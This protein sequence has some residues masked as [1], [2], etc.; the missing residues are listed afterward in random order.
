MRSRAFSF[1]SIA[2]EPQRKPQF[3]RRTDCL[4]CHLLPQTSGVPGLFA[5][6]QLPLSDNKNDY[7]QG[8][9]TDHRTPI[10]DRW[11]GWY[12]TGTQ[13]PARHLGN[14]PVVH[15]PRSYVRA[16]V[17]PRLDV[18]SLGL[19]RERVPDAAQRCRR[20]AGAES[21]AAY[22]ESP[23]PPRLGSA[24]RRTRGVAPGRQGA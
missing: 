7:A 13:V 8:W 4:E 23:D 2:Q 18:G 20:A 1:Y 15:V 17:A 24:R 3:V 5:M 11:G 21:P 6:S 16:D 22:D 14:V 10:E 19:R 12:V 9:A